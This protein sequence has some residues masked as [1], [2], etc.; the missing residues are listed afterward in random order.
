M[1]ENF[2]NGSEMSLP[3]SKFQFMVY[4][5]GLLFL[6]TSVVEYF[7]GNG[8]NNRIESL[9]ENEELSILALLSL[10]EESN[11]YI[12]MNYISDHKLDAACNAKTSIPEK[13]SRFEQMGLV[14]K[15]EDDVPF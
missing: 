13:K 12:A 9:E 5:L 8:I 10:T 11:T 14:E 7:A 6:T 1:A 3:T 4:L 15:K 2:K